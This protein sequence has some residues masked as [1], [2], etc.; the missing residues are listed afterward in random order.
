VEQA[1]V[2]FHQI[3]ARERVARMSPGYVTNMEL[4]IR[5]FSSTRSVLAGL[6]VCCMFLSGCASER[7][8]LSLAERAVDLFHSQFDSEEYSSIYQAAS[9]SMKEAASESN[10][11][12]LL[13]GVHRTLGAV[14]ASAPA[15]T[16]F[17]MAQGTIRL[18][19]D[20][21]FVRGSGREQFV[22]QFEDNQAI[23]YSYH[24]ESRDLD[25]R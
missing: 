14:Q 8:N 6:L 2:L 3:H 15:G 4:T 19:Y 20:T 16:T 18:D 7:R 1:E 10:F 12:E 13:Q 17:Q 23:L 21:T 24:I 11:V 25:T 22:W 9:A 5:L